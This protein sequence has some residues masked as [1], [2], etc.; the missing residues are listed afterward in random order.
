[1]RQR[2]IG[3][4]ACGHDPQTR[5]GVLLVNLGTPDAPDTASVRRYLH[6]FLWD[7]RVVEMPRTLWWAIL[8][9]VILRLRPRRS[10]RAY[11]TVW[12]A[13]G[14][15]LLVHSLALGNALASTL[16]D[17]AD[18]LFR[19]AVAMRYGQPAIGSAIATLVG[20]GVSRLIVMPLYPQ[21]SATTTAAVFDAVTRELSRYRH[22][23]ELIFETGYHDDPRYIDAI[24]QSIREHW[25]EHGE[26][27]RLLFSFH[28]IPQRYA[29]AGDPYHDHCQA[30]AQLIAQALALPPQRWQ[31]AFQSRVGREPWLKPYVDETLAQWGRQGVQNAHVICPG[32]AVDCLETLEEIASENRARFLAAGGGKFSY[33]PALNSREAHCAVF[34][35]RIELATAHWLA[36]AR[37]VERPG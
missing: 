34:A 6:E 37:H 2:Y 17:T 16:A 25:Q 22:V 11:R 21:Y 23:P 8:H 33:I 32:F 30:S 26:P 1:M 5:I 28:G 13:H 31:V 18:D 35:Q 36:R 29:R 10:A 3:S 19:V 4:E 14:S 7:P 15:P 27:Q 12:T 9:G 24:A 20:Q